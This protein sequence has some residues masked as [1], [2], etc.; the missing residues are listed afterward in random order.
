M[1]VNGFLQPAPCLWESSQLCW[2]A[3]RQGQS[4]W[5]SPL[6]GYTKTCP[7]SNHLE[8]SLRGPRHCRLSR[9]VWCI[10]GTAVH[11]WFQ[12]LVRPP[13]LQVTEIKGCHCSVGCWNVERL[14]FTGRPI[15]SNYHVFT[16]TSQFLFSYGDFCHMVFVFIGK[17]Q[18]IQLQTMICNIF[19]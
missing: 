13:Q 5:R 10:M 14:L 19:Q 3:F 11:H 7:R 12:W 9:R 1:T 16:S 2:L 6:I 4:A 15:T 18:E 17:L 8:R